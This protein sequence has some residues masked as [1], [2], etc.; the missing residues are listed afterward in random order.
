[1]GFKVR[2]TAH[3]LSSPSDR[4]I[5]MGSPV[6]RGVPQQAP[7]PM[8]K[9][10][11]VIREYRPTVPSMARMLMDGAEIPAAAILDVRLD[12]RSDWNWPLDRIL[13]VIRHE[14]GRFGYLLEYSQV[15]DIYTARPYRQA[16]YGR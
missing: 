2:F 9:I 1:M 5:Y 15:G 8:K 14:L 13:P 12:E 10:S 3:L 11:E 4:I 7:L 16:R 6:P